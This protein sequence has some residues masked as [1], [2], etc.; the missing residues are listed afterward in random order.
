MIT[1]GKRLLSLLLCG[2]ML[3]GNA[4]CSESSS[5]TDTTPSE[6]ESDTAGVQK[7]E[8]ETGYLDDIPEGT[9]FGGES[10]RFIL[11]RDA[12]II[13]FDEE[14]QELGEALNEAVWK[15][16]NLLTERLDVTIEKPIVAVS[17]QLTTII[18][19]VVQAGTDEYDIMIGHARFNADLVLRNTIRSLDDLQYLDLEKPY[20]SQGFNEN[21]AY[22]G[23]HFWIVGDIS[24]YYI[25]SSY[26]I[27]ANSMLWNDYYKDEN[28][29]SIVREGNWTIDK[30]KEFTSAVYEDANGNGLKD[31]EDVFGFAAGASHTYNGMFFA[32]GIQYTTPDSEG[33]PQIAINS[34]H[35]ANV[36]DKLS[37]FL[38]NGDGVYKLS[39]AQGDSAL[40]LSMF[41]ADRLLFKPGQISDL[42]NGSV[43]NMDTDF[44]VIPMPKYDEAQENYR[45]SQH[46]GTSIYGI[47]STVHED[48]LDAVSATLEAMCSMASTMV[49]PVY[50]DD[51]LKSKYSR[52][53]ETA[54][55]ID[56]IRSSLETDFGYV[57]SD[58]ISATSLFGFFI[59]S[60]EKDS[61]ASSLEKANKL[62]VNGLEALVESLDDIASQYN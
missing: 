60:I 54:E 40:D 27:L 57:W 36:F 62:W 49:I 33:I 15:R 30:L 11:N 25:S 3:L 53:P 12:E 52:D 19:N 32:A 24:K 34:E 1:K 42:E 7:T 31:E 20:W 17:S 51:I 28:L 29:Y 9:T 56:L 58:S 50:Y 61:I 18:P 4:S 41:V 43:R 39:D 26:I 37:T 5:D 47:L 13:Y 6:N 22:D 55:M 35:S 38:K 8:E 16:N 48:R 59:S 10:I 21:V 23:N 46:D 45:S 44:Y 2:L 14:E